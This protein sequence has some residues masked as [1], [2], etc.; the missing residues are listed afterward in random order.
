MTNRLVSRADMRLKPIVVVVLTGAS[1]SLLLFGV[2]TRST[3]A[4]Q[5]AAFMLALL[6]AALTAGLAIARTL[7][8]WLGSST[9]D[10]R[11]PGVCSTCHQAM[12]D[13]EGIWLCSRCDTSPGRH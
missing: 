2:S 3:G 8:P 9:A 7:E 5:A 4:P 10:R 11:T 12:E 6:A 13:T 1:I